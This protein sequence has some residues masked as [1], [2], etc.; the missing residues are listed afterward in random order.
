MEECL[1]SLQHVRIPGHPFSMHASCLLYTEPAEDILT[2]DSTI[3]HKGHAG[4]FLGIADVVQV[5]TSRPET[6]LTSSLG[7]SVNGMYIDAELLGNR[8]WFDKSADW[9]PNLV[10]YWSRVRC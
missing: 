10:K 1:N 9:A 6:G 5:P 2:I 4:T 3:C 7:Q 8:A